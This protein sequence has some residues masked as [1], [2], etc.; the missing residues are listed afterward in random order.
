MST[1]LCFFASLLFAVKSEVGSYIEHNVTMQEVTGDEIVI[2]IVGQYVNISS[3]CYINNPSQQHTAPMMT[4]GGSSPS[5]NITSAKWNG[6][7]TQ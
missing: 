6:S 5:I 2:H 4:Q 3:F 7:S 1:M